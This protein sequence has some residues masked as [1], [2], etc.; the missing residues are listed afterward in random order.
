MI[1]FVKFLKPVK[2]FGKNLMRKK[3]LQIYGIGLTTQPRLN[4][5]ER[6]SGT[7]CWS[8]LYRFTRPEMLARSQPFKTLLMTSARALGFWPSRGGKTTSR[9]RSSKK[10]SQHTS[11]YPPPPSVPGAGSASPWGP[12]ARPWTST[13]TPSS[14]ATRSR[15]TG[16]ACVTTPSNRPYSR[17]PASPRFR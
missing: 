15:A 4:N 16:G 10:P 12:K 11:A 7:S 14:A 13:E 8:A 2:S 1:F 17:R 3:N 5:R 9:A 6:L